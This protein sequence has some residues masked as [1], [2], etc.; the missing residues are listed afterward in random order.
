[1]GFGLPAA[2]GAKLGSP[3]RRVVCISGDG[4]FLMNLQELITAAEEE[5]AAVIL[6]MNDSCLG[7]IKQLQDAF[8]GGRHR[9]CSLGG[10]VD[11]AGIAERM[12]VK[13]YRVQ[14]REDLTAALEAAEAFEGTTVIDC[15]I[16]N[17][18]N[19]Y[20]MVTGGSLTDCIEED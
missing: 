7:M 3:D 6:I 2:L 12:G 20:P 19:V 4:S 10:C 15:V 9:S 13:G 17:P 16:D 11:F 5:I 1:M 18:T 14:N 8:Y